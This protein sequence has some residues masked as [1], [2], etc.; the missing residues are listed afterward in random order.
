MVRQYLLIHQYL[1]LFLEISLTDFLI[2]KYSLSEDKL[3]YFESGGLVTF[4]DSF[5]HCMKDK[6][7]GDSLMK[8]KDIHTTCLESRL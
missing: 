2:Y 6:D 5:R 1:H 4:D 3:F 8:K 7:L